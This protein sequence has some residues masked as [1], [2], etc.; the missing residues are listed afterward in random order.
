MPLFLVRHAHAGSRHKWD[1]P[2]ELRPLSRRGRD[3]AE[4]IAALLGDEPIE[5]V[6]SSP[7]VRCVESVEPLAAK[8]GLEVE[9]VDALR[10]GARLAESIG[11][12]EDLAAAGTTAVLCSH[13]DVIPDVLTGL[14]RRG[15]RLDPDG[16]L[17]KGSIWVLEVR[18]GA[19]S[20]ARY[21][22]SGPPPSTP[23]G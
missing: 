15:A 12:V 7:L 16:A 8:R 19:V 14:A 11:L 10:E 17:P 4:E 5:R 2:D 22:G 20:E 3:R 21:A 1:G 13:G 9:A 6:L 18:D 23:R